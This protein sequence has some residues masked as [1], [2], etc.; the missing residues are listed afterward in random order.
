MLSFKDLLNNSEEAEM[1]SKLQTLL[2]DNAWFSLIYQKTENITEFKHIISLT[3]N[4]KTLI[5]DIK[6]NQ[7]NQI[8]DNYNL[9]GIKLYSDTQTWAHY[10]SIENCDSMGRN[11]EMKG[12]LNDM[13]NAMGRILNFT[14]TSHA[15]LDGV[16]I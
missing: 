16:E 10:F 8:I 14:W 2:T 15:S 7:F 4:T 6:F 9:E 3:N 5:Q 1:K 11:C 13:M 12:V